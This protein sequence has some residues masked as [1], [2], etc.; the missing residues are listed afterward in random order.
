[1]QN[2]IH[3]AMYS[4][5]RYV[6]DV[7]REEFVNVGVALVCPAL[8]FQ[9]VLVLPHFGAE[10]RI[11]VF[12]DTDGQFVRHAVHK[13]RQAFADKS[14]NELLE[15]PMQ[16]SLVG[17]DLLT[18][19]EIY[20]VNNVQ[21]SM[22]RSVAVT[23]SLETLQELFAMFV[24]DMPQPKQAKSVTRKVIR[25]AVHDVFSQRGLFGENLVLEDWEV[26]VLTKPIVDFSY[27][28]EVRH[29]FQAISLEAPDRV[30][31]NAVN[32]YRQTAHDVREYSTEDALKNAHFVVLGHVPTQPSTRI[33]TLLEVLKTDQIEFADYREAESIA[34][35]IEVH[36]QAHQPLTSSLR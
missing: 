16:E 17:Q 34:Q 9:Q 7:L 11:K 4:V 27:L 35:D 3:S 8:E 25:S 10:S 14:I 12:D 20:R 26:P 5:L 32:A 23:N 28:N 18:L 31:T 13:L 6:P 30:M 15:K 1:M 2:T 24:G 36:L 21:L 29:C 19:F 22:P 33:N